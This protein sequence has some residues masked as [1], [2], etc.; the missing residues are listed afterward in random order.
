MD[1]SRTPAS[2][3]VPPT[4]NSETLPPPPD[5][6]PRSRQP[7]ITISF[8]PRSVE[9]APSSSVPPDIPTPQAEE[10]QP[11]DLQTNPTFLLQS[12]AALQNLLDGIDGPIEVTGPDPRTHF[13]S[14]EIEAYR[15]TQRANQESHSAAS[16]SRG[17]EAAVNLQAIAFQEEEKKECPICTKEFSEG[18]ITGCE[19]FF[20]EGCISHWLETGDRCPM[21]RTPI[22]N[23]RILMRGA[24]TS[25]FT[26][27]P[28]L[29]ER[30]DEM[31]MFP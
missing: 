21:C 5:Q 20:C 9:P 14:E 8:T 7:L 12:A 16:G 30:W 23:G 4:T 24:V 1:L 6:N 17:Q 15:R 13:D 10:A 11:Q 3:E 25:I 26:L 22:R 29:R 28:G 18:K 27:N 31:D 19:H 2:D